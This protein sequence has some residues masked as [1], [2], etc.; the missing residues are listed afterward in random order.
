V[1]NIKII[2]LVKGRADPNTSNGVNIVIH[3][4]A[5]EQK[6]LN[7]D[8][9]VW[10]ITKNIHLN[11]H[12]HNYPLSLFK[13]KIIFKLDFNLIKRINNLK[14]NTI[15]HFHSG[16][17]IEF[18]LIAKILKKRGIKWI[19]TPHS[20]FYSKKKNTFKQMLKFFYK[21]FFE[22]FIIKNTSAIHALSEEESKL[23]SRKIKKNKIYI[24]PNGVR[25]SLLF[26]KKYL[27]NK[28]FS[29]CYCGRIAI[30]QKG[31]DLLLLAINELKKKNYRIYLNIIGDGH[32]KSK[33][34]KMAYN[35]K[36]DDMITF[37]GNKIGNNKKKLIVKNDIFIHTSRFEGIPMAVLEAASLGMPLVISKNTNLSKF[38]IKANSGYVIKSLQIKH[39]SETIEKII[40][41]RNKI[42]KMGIN[43]RMMA[44]G[45]FSWKKIAI[46]LNKK[47]YSQI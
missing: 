28:I 35:L 37:H 7:I 14:E 2:H 1:K 29:I 46:T 47:I 9:E 40:K 22:D 17:I 20:L 39:I 27:K 8:T 16:F 36:I 33:L 18:Y 4:L 42:K 15:V 32:Q 41:N 12:R 21:F 6:K 13:Q 5:S 43:S 45:N 19:I 44:I 10:G 26:K 38:I 11:K 31:L 25:K 30:F 34:E 23:W 24:I 3:N